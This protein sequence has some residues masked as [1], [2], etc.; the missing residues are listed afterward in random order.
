MTPTVYAKLLC[1]S[2]VFLWFLI[3]ISPSLWKLY[4]SQIVKCIC[5]L[6]N[7]TNKDQKYK[8][9]I[10]KSICY[11]HIVQLGSSSR[12]IHGGAYFS[13]VFGRKFDPTTVLR[14]CQPLACYWRVGIAPAPTLF[15][16]SAKHH[17]S[18][19]CGWSDL[20]LLFTSICQGTNPCEQ[21]WQIW[22]STST[23]TMVFCRCFVEVVNKVGAE[24]MPKLI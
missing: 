22:P 12:A 8:N 17:G 5:L 18:R 6:T 4:F 23:G 13:A 21:K 20:S 16:T 3:H 9:I 7:S 2:I 19:W 24:A 10:E 15:T 1:Q 11:N 14:P